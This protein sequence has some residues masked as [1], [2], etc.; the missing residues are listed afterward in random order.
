MALTIENEEFER[1]VQ[2]NARSAGLSV[3]DYLTQLLRQDDERAR[4]LQ[5]LR[6][7]I[8]EGLASLDRGEGVDGEEF[9]ANL[10]AGLDDEAVSKAG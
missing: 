1:H 4:Q 10:L 2:T 9:M 3:E 6:A 5:D 7:R 8:S